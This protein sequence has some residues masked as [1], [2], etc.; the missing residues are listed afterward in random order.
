MCV[1]VTQAPLDRL[2]FLGVR[3]DGVLHG[4]A[5]MSGGYADYVLQQAAQARQCSR[6]L[7]TTLPYCA[8]AFEYTTLLSSSLPYPRVP[9]PYP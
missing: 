8:L 9:F 4:R 5:G 7:P 1:N 2:A 3:D 6:S